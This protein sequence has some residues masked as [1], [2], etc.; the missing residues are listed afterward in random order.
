MRCSVIEPDLL[1]CYLRYGLA[2]QKEISPVQKIEPM[3]EGVFVTERHS[4]GPA[5]EGGS[6]RRHTAIVGDEKSKNPHARISFFELIVPF[7]DRRFFLIMGLSHCLFNRGHESEEAG[8]TRPPIDFY[9]IFSPEVPFP[10][11]YI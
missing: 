8:T 7:L 6:R 10:F 4:H 2:I 9:K 3:G 5:I 1:G 11:P